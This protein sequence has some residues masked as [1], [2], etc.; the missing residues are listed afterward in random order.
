M[1]DFKLNDEMIIA[2]EEH[3]KKLQKGSLNFQ[4][5][6]FQQRVLK[7]KNMNR[8]SKQ[9]LEKSIRR[10]PTLNNTDPSDGG[11]DEYSTAAEDDEDRISQD[12]NEQN[13]PPLR[14]ILSKKHS[15]QDDP[16]DQV[17]HDSGNSLMV[18]KGDSQQPCCSKSLPLQSSDLLEVTENDS[19]SMICP[20]E[21]H[22]KEDSALPTL[23]S[24]IGRKR[25]PSNPSINTIIDVKKPKVTFNDKSNTI[26]IQLSDSID[27]TNDD[28]ISS[29][30]RRGAIEEYLGTSSGFLNGRFFRLATGISPQ[31]QQ[32]Q[33]S[34]NDEINQ[35]STDEYVSLG[36][37]VCTGSRQQHGTNI[38]D[39]S[40]RS[41]MF[42][43]VYLFLL[44][45][46]L[47]YLIH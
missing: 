40:I 17:K 5:V 16:P 18:E 20:P 37:S 9:A 21:L 11:E 43:Y 33:S 3:M 19:S 4:R 42:G 47:R 1:L 45:T 32:P 23:S 25:K 27:N 14:G 30:Y 13:A 24:G 44:F 41:R 10:M 28:A 29:R 26:S 35:S 8:L 12:E 7:G 34:S 39:S 6:A 15:V 38:R 46:F 31:Q 2:D 22:S 36:G